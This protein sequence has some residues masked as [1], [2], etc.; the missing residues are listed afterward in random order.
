MKHLIETANPSG[1]A[2]TEYD[3]I[4]LNSATNDVIV[5]GEANA[6]GHTYVDL[7]LPSGLKWATMNVGAT[8]E[9]DYGYYFQ[10]GSTTS[11]NNTPC[12]WEHAPFNG[13]NTSY[14]ANAFNSAKDTACP[15][16]VLAKEYD[17]AS[18]IM[19]GD[20]RMPTD[21]EISELLSNT[22]KEW[23]EKYNGSA[24]NGCK[25]TSKTDTSKYIFIPAA[26]LRSGSS[27]G[28][29]YIGHVWSS[30]LITSNPSKAYAFY[31]EYLN[32]GLAINGYSRYLGALVRGVL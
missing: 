20:W 1:L 2:I 22:D 24:V 16:G 32:I 28:D 31:F 10:W 26:G 11:N 15:N 14:N 3:R 17:A 12:D 8:S 9:T 13:G 27:D 18:Q 19:G 4:I 5:R 7:G 23:I 30:S 25:F 29:K 6:N 21:A